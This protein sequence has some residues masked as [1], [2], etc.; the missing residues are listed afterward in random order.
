[1][2]CALTSS[3]CEASRRSTSAVKSRAQ[4]LAKARGVKISIQPAFTS[5]FSY[6]FRA[7][8]NFNFGSFFYLAKLV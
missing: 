3:P 2:P 6:E 4:R 7:G 5:A 1:M 8:I